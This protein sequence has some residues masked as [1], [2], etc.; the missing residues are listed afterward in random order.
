MLV[1]ILIA[2]HD[3]DDALHFGHQ[4]EFILQRVRGFLRDHSIKGIPHNCDQ[5]VQE[6]DLRDDRGAQEDQIAEREIHMVL[7]AFQAEI[8]QH[9]HVL[10]KR[11][12]DNWDI[13]NGLDEVAVFV[14]SHHV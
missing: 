7:E 6:G 14:S 5:H 10:V 3:V 9:E 8:T 13:E 11:C 2:T 12:V 4:L 1:L